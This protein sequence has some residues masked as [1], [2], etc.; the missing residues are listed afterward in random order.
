MSK[1]TVSR[2][3]CHFKDDWID[4]TLF[5]DYA[6]WVVK[7]SDTQARCKLCNNGRSIIDL[8]VLGRSALNSHAKTKM[9]VDK[10]SPKQQSVT[11]FFQSPPAKKLS[12]TNNNVNPI[13]SNNSQPSRTA[14]DFCLNLSNKSVVR[15]DKFCS[16]DDVFRAEILFALCQVH[17][18]ASLRCFSDLSNCFPIMFSDS[19]IAKKFKMHKD[20]LSYSITYGLGPFFQKDLAR[21]IR[22]SEFYTVS[23]DESL[24]K[25]AQ[26]GQMDIIVKKWIDDKATDTNYLTSCFLEDATA[27]G[28][29]NAFIE[30]LKSLRIDLKK[31]YQ[32]SMDGPN[33]NLKFIR[34]FKSHMKD[35]YGE[36]HLV[37]IDIGTCSLHVVNNG[38]KTGLKKSG[39]KIEKYL[40]ASYYLFKDVPIRRAT[41]SRITQS[42]E[43][44]FKFCSIR[45]TENVRVFSRSLDTVG[46]MRLY[47]NSVS[48]KP[49]SSKNFE[50]VKKFV[51]DPFLEAKLSF[52]IC[53]SYELE[54]YLIT[55]QKNEPLIPFMYE[56]LFKMLKSLYTRIKKPEISKNIKRAEDLLKIQLEE[57]ENLCLA[58]YVDLGVAATTE[59]KRLKKT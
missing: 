48:K 27:S 34:D 26:K 50:T 25:V 2:G 52:L 42:Y 55:Y 51:A 43:F 3:T 29:L 39:W 37:L 58:I 6:Q 38:Y 14:N 18:Y 40:R 7:V 33:V 46:K 45:W 11:S 13:A 8:K 35:N 56:D 16:N 23:F 21:Q 41:Y 31:I 19:N 47:V 4:P 57:K 24:N 32:V 15:L 20:K 28:L 1:K 12:D 30:A 17:K 44:P 54:P 36:D 49:P 9:H 10:T 5:P 59:V 53:V 22:E